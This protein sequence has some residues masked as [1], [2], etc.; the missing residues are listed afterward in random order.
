M[1][2]SMAES[3]SLEEGLDIGTNSERRLLILKAYLGKI[4]YL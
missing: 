3:N 2:L 4:A 1:N